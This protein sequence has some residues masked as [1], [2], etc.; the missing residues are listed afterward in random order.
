MRRYM[1]SHQ[2]EFKIPEESIALE[3]ASIDTAGNAEEVAKWLEAKRTLDGK[4]YASIGLVTVGY[5]IKRATK[6]FKNFG[7]PI[8]RKYKSEQIVAVRSPKHETL[9][10]KWRKSGNVLVES[11]FK[12]PILRGI[13]TFD[14]Q[15][16]TLRKI[17]QKSRD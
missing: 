7:V 5:H 2:R 8:D 17:T 1:Q 10:E 13:S 3:E 9:V 16:K 14:K 6:L 12:E 11:Y 15:G 4:E